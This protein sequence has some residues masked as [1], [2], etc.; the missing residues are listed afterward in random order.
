M[1]ASVSSGTQ[2]FFN[3]ASDAIIGVAQWLGPKGTAGLGCIARSIR[4]QLQAEGDAGLSKTWQR[5]LDDDF[6]PTAQ[7][8]AQ[9]ACTPEDTESRYLGPAQLYHLCFALRRRLDEHLEVVRGSVAEEA[10][11]AECV[12][13]PVLTHLFDAG[14]GAQGAV[15]QAAGQRLEKFIEHLRKLR[16]SPVPLQ[17]GEVVLAPGGNLAKSVALVVTE[18]PEDAGWT[19]L[20]LAALLLET[21]RRLVCA[22]RRSGYRSV[23]LPTLGTGGMGYPVSLVCAAVA[24]A[25]AEDFARHPSEPLRV[26]VCCFERH[27]FSTMLDSRR[28]ALSWAFGN[29]PDTALGPSI[30]SGNMT[31]GNEMQDNNGDDGYDTSDASDNDFFG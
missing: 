7:Q 13:C 20:S 17:P 6:G 29:G 26:R 25:V 14:I 9:R 15:R 18:P 28:L 10:G 3:L 4:A 19:R 27:H 30:I 31:E 1:P 5:W 2:N 23:A 8:V 21:H 12:A 24:K 22:V 16:G 11:G